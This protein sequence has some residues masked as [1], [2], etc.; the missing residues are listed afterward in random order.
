MTAPGRP[1]P[2]DGHLQAIVR[3]LEPGSTVLV[4]APP[5]AGKTTRV[6]LTL[7]DSMGG[8]GR[9]LLLEPR[10]LAAKAAAQRLA[11]GLGEPVGGRVGYSVRLDSRTSAATRLEVVTGGI[12]LRRLQADPALEE[13]D[14]VIFDEFHERG[15]EADLA[16]AMLRQARTLL[17]PELR[18]LIMSAT[19]DL[20]PLA[21]SIDNAQ[22]ITSEG[23]S[24]PVEVGY[25]PPRSQERLEHQV[26]RSLEEQW[27]PQRGSQE[28]VLVFL[29]GQRE[30]QACRQAIASTPWGEGLECAALHGQ[31]PL[32]AQGKAIRPSRCPEGKVV[33]ATSIAESS[34]T[35]EGVRLVIDSGWSRRNRFHPAR[36]MEGLVTVTASRASAEQRRGRAGRLGPGR[37]LRLW[38]E[39]E[40]Q[41]RPPFDAP[42]ILEADPLPLALQLAAWG[43][44]LGEE[45]PWLTPPAREPLAEAR[46]LL[47]QLGAL[48]ES[49]HLTG[50]GRAMNRLGLHPRLGHMLLKAQ[51][52]GWLDLGSALAVLLSERDPLPARLAGCDLMRRLEW[53]RRRADDP[54]AWSAPFMGEP[55]HREEAQRHQFRRLQQKL[56]LQVG[57]DGGAAR[58]PAQATG[59]SEEVLAARLISWAFPERIAV[60]RERRDGRFLLRSGRGAMVHPSDPLAAAGALAIANVDGEGQEARVLLAVELPPVV[61][62]E[63]ASEEG[64]VEESAQW[65]SHGER[66]RCERVLR[67][68]ALALRREPWSGACG[69][70]VGMAL[71][72]GLRQVGLTGL[73]WCRRSRQLQERLALAHIHL[74]CP[75]PDRSPDQLEQNLADWLGPHLE[76]MR[77]LRDLQRIDLMAALWGDLD[78]HHRQQLADLL[79]E[80]WPLPSGRRARIDYSNGQPVLAVKLQDMFGCTHTPSLLQGELPLT[81]HLLSPAGRPTAI[82][83]D[84]P[85][86]WRN[87]YAE[88]RRELRGRYPRH[89]W[90]EKPWQAEAAPLTRSRR[91]RDP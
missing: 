62:E 7:L 65:D 66:V 41:R 20:E 91:D 88:V 89:A 79:P 82:T 47:A 69:Q 22:V 85:G 70:S 21:T 83:R 43:A 3:A 14:C 27:L 80:E 5:G 55:I 26:L 29:P 67:L 58:P 72:D 33:L 39:A 61:L 78:W 40:Q 30:I 37:C 32:A 76:G 49:G 74:G 18:I 81:I 59:D 16:L 71:L 46:R 53:L 28:T 19:L 51:E 45:L 11:A 42:E 8:G 54:C 57:F 86:F 50:H 35:I 17:R 13:V 1:L 75:W 12:F 52:R 10:R 77:S 90:P 23:R 6:P 24:H 34:L 9:I 31:L 87:G 38:S 25:Q 63:L 4:Q 73:P 84:L 60:A 64:T 48:D 56:L 36:G 15:S 44:G 68:G 2:I